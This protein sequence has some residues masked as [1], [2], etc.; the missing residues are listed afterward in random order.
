L[1]EI[2]LEAFNYALVDWPQNRMFCF[3][4]GGPVLCWI[5][6]VHEDM[7]DSCWL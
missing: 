5:R 3:E 1:P 2:I 7:L 4:A 6:G